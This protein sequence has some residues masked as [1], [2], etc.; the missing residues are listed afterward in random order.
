MKLARGLVRL[1]R[2]CAVSREKFFSSDVTEVDYDLRD[3][4]IRLSRGSAYCLLLAGVLVWLALI[5]SAPVA[6]GEQWPGSGLFYLFFHPICHQIPERSFFLGAHPLPVCQR[7]LGIYLGFGIGLFLFPVLPALT[8]L[9]LS[10]PRLLVLFFLPL[11]LNVLMQNA[12]WD[13][14]L[15][16]LAAGF[17]VSPFVWAAL[18]RMKD[19]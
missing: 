11:G 16:G 15:T 12:P 13:R 2:W 9:L 18:S 17:P 8:R 1:V 7:C 3:E 6:R 14:F 5:A 19:E 4:M 10:K